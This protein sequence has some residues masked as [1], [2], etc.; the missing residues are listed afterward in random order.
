M[1]ERNRLLNSDAYLYYRKFD[2]KQTTDQESNRSS[3]TNDDCVICLTGI[4]YEPTELS[5]DGTASM[6]QE[7]QSECKGYM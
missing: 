2:S 3:D 6:S 5:P 1:R 4:K 7:Q